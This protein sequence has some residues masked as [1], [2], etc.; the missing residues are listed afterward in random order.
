MNREEVQ[1]FRQQP[2]AWAQG[3]DHPANRACALI[4]NNW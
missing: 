2:S 3:V 1:L 4:A